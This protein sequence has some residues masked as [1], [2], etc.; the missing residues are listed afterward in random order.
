M[1]Q[2]PF[3]MAKMSYYILSL[4]HVSLTTQ[5]P[6]DPFYVSSYPLVVSHHVNHEDVTYLALFQHKGAGGI[7]I[8]DCGVEL[9]FC[10]Q[11]GHRATVVCGGD[12]IQMI[13]T[14]PS[15]LD[16][17]AL[18]GE[19]DVSNTGIR[20]YKKKQDVSWACTTGTR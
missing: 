16:R 10:T 6:V 4:L 18:I 14:V 3:S 12:A 5:R 2:K 8:I 20:A 11:R 13:G 7:F 17:K 1:G 9:L 19:M 15:S